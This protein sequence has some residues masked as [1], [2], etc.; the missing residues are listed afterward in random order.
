MLTDTPLPVADWRPIAEAPQDGAQI[1]VPIGRDLV[2]VVSFWGGAWREG[3]N[4]LR[5]ASE[6]DVFMHA[7]KV[8]A[9]LARAGDA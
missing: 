9:T 6:P 8:P 2:D 7:P 1:I 3:T 5:L 4:G